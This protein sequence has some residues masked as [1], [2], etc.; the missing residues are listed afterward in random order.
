MTYNLP[1]SVYTL[2][3]ILRC[4]YIFFEPWVLLVWAWECVRLELSSSGMTGMLSP[5]SRQVDLHRCSPENSIP[6]ELHCIK[7]RRAIR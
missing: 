2:Q 1:K 6:V 3:Y 7:T 4:A 5:S